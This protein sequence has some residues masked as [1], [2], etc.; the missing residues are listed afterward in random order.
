MAVRLTVPLV[1][2]RLSMSCWYA[3][4]CMVAYYRAPGPRLGLPE[5]WVLNQGITQSS[6]A[7]LAANEGLKGVLNPAGDLTS[8]QLE[9]LLRNHGPIWCAGHWY[10]FGHVVVLTGVDGD[11]VFINDPDGPR[12]KTGTRSWF[13]EKLGK[14][15]WNPCMMYMP[16]W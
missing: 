1:G 4:V 14:G 7:Q 3:S 8:Q 5:K 12:A 10:G 13:N 6:F 2:Q 9:V 16:A 11:T 15:I